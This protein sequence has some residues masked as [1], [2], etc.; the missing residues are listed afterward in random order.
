MINVYLVEHAKS[1]PLLFF[2]CF[3]FLFLTLVFILLRLFNQP[4]KYRSTR[5]RRD[6]LIVNRAHQSVSTWEWW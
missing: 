5:T 1:K 3:V 6:A 4:S 2:C